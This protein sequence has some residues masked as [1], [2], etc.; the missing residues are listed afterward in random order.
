[1]RE[2]YLL[3][4][5]SYAVNG[6]KNRE[7]NLYFMSLCATIRKTSFLVNSAVQSII[8]Y[9]L[10]ILRSDFRQSRLLVISY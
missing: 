2:L 3:V 1:M 10:S 4:A 7:Y 8:A 6:I 9:Y 5:Y